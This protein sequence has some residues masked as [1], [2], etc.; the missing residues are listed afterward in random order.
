M[1]EQ[2]EDIPEM[3]D[4]ELAAKVAAWRL[5]ASAYRST[6]SYHRGGGVFGHT[7]PERQ[8]DLDGMVRYGESLIASRKATV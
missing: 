2:I 6:Y 5:A 3:S 7:K 8:A 1:D 4:E